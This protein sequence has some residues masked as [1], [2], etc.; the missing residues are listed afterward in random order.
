MVTLVSSSPSLQSMPSD[1]L[2]QIALESICS[3]D[4]TTPHDLG[5]IVSLILTCRFFHL[6]LSL[7][8]NPDLYGKVFRFM[9]DVEA[10]ERRLGPNAV[11]SS[12]L[13]SALKERLE[14][15]S[16][17]IISFD[18]SDSQIEEDGMP[19]LKCLEKVYLVMTEDDGKNRY[20]LLRVARRCRLSWLLRRGQGTAKFDQ[21]SGHALPRPCIATLAFFV[22]LLEMGKSHDALVKEDPDTRNAILDLF[23]PFVFGFMPSPLQR[24]Q[25]VD[26]FGI[27]CLYRPPS[28]IALARLCTVT[29]YS[30]QKSS[31]DC[32]EVAKS[33][34]SKHD[35]D[36]A[37]LVQIKPSSISTQDMDLMQG[38]HYG[39][40]DGKWEGAFF[41]SSPVDPP[42]QVITCAQKMEARLREYVCFEEN[43]RLTFVDGEDNEMMNLGRAWMP[44]GT[45]LDETVTVLRVYDPL[46]KQWLKYHSASNIVKGHCHQHKTQTISDSILVGEVLIL[47]H[48][49]EPSKGIQLLMQTDPERRETSDEYT[50][51]GRIKY[52]ERVISLVRKP[53]DPRMSD[54][55]SW[56]FYGEIH[57]TDLIGDWTAAFSTARTPG[58]HGWFHLSKIHNSHR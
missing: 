24:L 31:A 47:L 8:S 5:T 27:P 25:P 37:R 1:V 11:R 35:D 10:I 22:A 39:I 14:A 46:K 3:S 9:F 56:V 26:L 53:T 21:G 32:E 13:A 30:A 34:S 51:I 23:E 29:R 38:H 55:G 41:M 57:G 58:A 54:L 15:F 18:D 50:F 28:L 16:A 6:T 43:Q 52:S 20:Q 45:A 7:S 48:V 33:P 42:P 4:I 44:L 40:F 36:W 19:L 49:P 2:C 12:A 17:L